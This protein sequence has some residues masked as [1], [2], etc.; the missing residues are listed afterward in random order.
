MNKTI[1]IVDDEADIRN[2]VKEILQDEGYKVLTAANSKEV[3]DILEKDKPDM[4]ILDIWLQDS[5]HDGLQILETIKSGAHASIPVIMISGHGNIET[6]VKAIKQGAYDFIEKPF[7]S[8]RLL[9]MIQR[10]LENA[11]LRQENEAL[12]A[13]SSNEV[14]IIGTSYH[15]KNLKERVKTLAKSNSRLMIEG[16]LGSGKTTIAKLIHA[17]SSSSGYP[18]IVFSCTADLQRQGSIEQ[19]LEQAENGYLVFQDIDAMSM[20][21]QKRLLSILSNE[22]VQSRVIATSRHPET[23]D[24]DLYKRINIETL[25]VPSLEQRRQDIADILNVYVH[26]IAA[27]LGLHV[28]TISQDVIRLC[29][30][31]KWDGNLYELQAAMIWALVHNDGADEI[32]PKSLP[33]SISGISSSL[34]NDQ[35]TD[36]MAQSF[37]D[38]PLREARE[39]FEYQYLTAQVKRFEDNISKT[40]LFVGMERSALHRKIKTLEKKNT[41][42][43]VTE[44]TQKQ[45]SSAIV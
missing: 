36:K 39:A 16:P 28:P 30:N 11:L 5:R 8:D 17:A 25:I 31:Y 23:L 37:L 35:N 9:L 19:A 24:N 20:D 43:D 12:K 29:E 27:E 14:D 38:L 34:G 15:A 42:V 40:A 41:Q 44:D 4:T 32:Q 26:Q 45:T 13:R 2:L 3:Y 33:L 7:K 18:L 1:L 22:Q 21:D 10:G 6:A